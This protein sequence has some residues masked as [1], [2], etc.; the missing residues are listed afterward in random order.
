MC[1]CRMEDAHRFLS[2]K[3]AIG[4]AYKLGNNITASHL[5]KRVLDYQGSPVN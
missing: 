3:N 2:L 1:V 5:C 4:V